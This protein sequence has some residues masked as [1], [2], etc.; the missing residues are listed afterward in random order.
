MTD[1]CEYKVFIKTAEYTINIT[2]R[3]L[4]TTNFVLLTEEKNIVL[5]TKYFKFYGKSIL[6]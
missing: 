1:M 4:A 2:W 3:L 6:N 5:V